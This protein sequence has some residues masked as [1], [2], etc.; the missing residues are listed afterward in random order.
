M[1]EKCHEFLKITGQQKIALIGE[2]GTL[3]D[4]DAIHAGKIGWASF[5]IWSGVFCLSEEFNRYEY[6][7]KLYES[8][9]AV[10][11]DRLPELY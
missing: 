2:S 10:T 4:V 6:M 11:K 9:Y 3:P 1:C 5:M 8:P 7:N